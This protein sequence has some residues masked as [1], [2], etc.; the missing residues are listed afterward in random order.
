LADFLILS[1]SDSVKLGVYSVALNRFS[2]DLFVHLGGIVTSKV[3]GLVLEEDDL[4][5][6]HTDLLHQI[7]MF[8]CVFIRDF[9]FLTTKSNYELI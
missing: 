7:F 2:L 6:G 5:V 8:H 1:L 4:V 3:G 9:M